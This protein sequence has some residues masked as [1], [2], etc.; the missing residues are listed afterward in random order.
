MRDHN[1]TEHIDSR[2]IRVFTFNI[3]GINLG[4]DVEQI[5][6][7]F[8]P[9]KVE[10]QNIQTFW[11]HEKISF[12]EGEVA[13]NSP[14]VLIIKDDTSAFGIIIDLPNDIFIISIDSIQPL[15]SIMKSSGR[16][17]PIWGAALKDEQIILLVDAY[18]LMQCETVTEKKMIEII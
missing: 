6:G 3:M 1:G 14:K 8:E 4:I 16:P 13:Y 9:D 2:E 5:A 12:P 18:R 17:E 10:A 7:L 11:F 15:P